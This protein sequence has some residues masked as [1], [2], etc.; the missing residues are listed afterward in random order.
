[1]H[2]YRNTYLLQSDNGSTSSLV[3]GS[4][5]T[6]DTLL[7]RSVVPANHTYPAANAK[8]GSLL[9]YNRQLTQ[10]T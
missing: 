2:I 10:L 7:G 8:E 1:M 9:Y 4:S 5:H 6:L 3:A